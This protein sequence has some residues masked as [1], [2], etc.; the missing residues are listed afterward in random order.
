MKYSQKDMM[1]I[2]NTNNFKFKKKYGQNF[3]ID[4]NVINNIVD[5]SEID[6]DTLVIE[7]GP[8]VG[9]LT[10]KLVQV[11]GFVICYE[12]DNT[13]K[14]I[15]NSNLAG[16][17]NYEVI[18]DDF[19]KRNVN[20]DIKKYNYDKV[21]IVANLPYY[22][23]T[24]IITKIIED[25]V[26]VYKMVFMVQKEVGDR[27]RA[28]PGQKEYN[29][30]TVYL[31]YYFNVVKLMDVSRNV[32][33]PIPNVDSIVVQFIKKDKLLNVDNPDLFF[34][35]I[36]DSFKQKRKTIKNN[37]QSYNLE[38]INKVL[39]KNGYNLTS[40]A[41]II[42]LNVFVELANELNNQQKCS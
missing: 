12:I 35:L 29:S 40:R 38:V 33:L 24:P 28:I 17:D 37:L 36:K 1:D 23:T 27:F 42:P 30:L 16:Y 7:I 18:F 6:K 4:Y 20:E 14:D 13:V 11:S 21:A 5:K 15:L 10:Y 3:I 22:I 25:K 8:G 31:N 9:S 41:E 34:K 19:L 32:F 26:D 2:L 39:H